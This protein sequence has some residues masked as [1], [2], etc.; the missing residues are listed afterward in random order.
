MDDRNLPSVRNHEDPDVLFRVVFPERQI[1]VVTRRQEQAVNKS[2]QPIALQARLLRITIPAQR[3]TGL[4]KLIDQPTP[5]LVRDS[6]RVPSD[7]WITRHLL[8]RA[9]DL[10]YMIPVRLF[11]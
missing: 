9:D 4:D 5:R 8:Q 7:R 3:Q 1:V 6:P 2:H 11:R 10:P